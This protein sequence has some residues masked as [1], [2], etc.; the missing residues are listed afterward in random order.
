MKD[1]RTNDWQNQLFVNNYNIMR[2]AR[3]DVQDIK[4]EMM[5]YE[6][7]EI[8][9]NTLIVSYMIGN[10]QGNGIKEFKLQDFEDW[11]KDEYCELNDGEYVV[12]I[13]PNPI[14]PEQESMSY[15]MSIWDYTQENE[16][17]L[18]IEY[19]NANK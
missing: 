14:S 13:T 18:V 9:D 19:F 6:Y 4:R 17:Q 11:V 15:G 2:N 1:Q 3:Q 5:S 7:H 8:E 10:K 16:K 12:W